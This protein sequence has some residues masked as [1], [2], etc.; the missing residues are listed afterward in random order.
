[1]MTRGIFPS[2]LMKERDEVAGLYPDPE[3]PA[4]AS[5]L[6]EKREFYDSRSIAAQ[7]TEGVI[8]PCSSSKA[9]AVFE[10]TPVQRL[11]SR[12][13]HPLTPYLGLLL[14]HGVGVGK[15]CS[16]V[17]IAEQFLDVSPNKVILLVPQAIQENFKKTIFDPAKL[18]WNGSSWSSQQCTRNT[19]LERLGLLTNPD[20]K[21]VTFAVEADRRKRYTITGYQAFANWIQ[22]SLTNHVPAGIEGDAKQI[23]ENEVLRK[24]FSDHLIIVDEAHNLRDVT[25]EEDTVVSAEAGENAGGKALNPFLKRIVLHAEGL[26]LVFMTATPMYNSAPEILRLLNFLIMNDT[27]REDSALQITDIFGPNGELQNSKT[28][29]D[30]ARRY[31]SYMRGEN[32]YT[33][34]LRMRPPFQES[35]SSQW[36]TVS[37][38]K[39]RVELTEQDRAA[40]DV[41][42]LIFTEPEP[43]SIVE[44]ALRGATSRGLEAPEQDQRDVMLDLRMQMSNITYPNNMYGTEGW[45]NYFK[46]VES[47]S[48]TRKIRTFAPKEDIRSVFRDN[49]KNHAPKI[50]RIVDS[51][52]SAQG[53]CFVYSRY[54]KSG[55]LP[56]AAALELAGFQRRLSDGSVVPLLSGV[57]PP[58]PICAICSSTH[59]NPLMGGGGGEAETEDHPFTPAYYILLTSDDEISPDFSGLV[60]LA[61]TWKDPLKGPLGTSV[62]VIIGSQVASEGLDLKCI[63]EMHILD[64]WY[65]L[66]RTDQIIGRAI[67][68]CSHS[69]LRPIERE[70]GIAPMAYNNC[71]IYMHVTIVKESERGPGFETADMYAY[72]L[73]IRKARNIGVVQ[74]VLKKHAWDCNLELEAIIFSGLPTR[75]QIDAQGRELAEY[76]LNDQDYTTYCD[77]Q[78]CKHECVSSISA[79]GGI[80]TS[81]YHIQDARREILSKMDIV[82][83]LFDDQV[84]IP[85]SMVQE[86][87]QDLPWEIRSEALLE[88]IDGKR[89]RIRRGKTE[90]YLIKKAGFL[91]FQPINIQDTDIPL[92]LRYERAFQI[93]RKF[94]TLTKPMNP[95]MEEIV[96]EKFPESVDDIDT[97]WTAWDTFLKGGALPSF[98]PATQRIWI[99]FRNHFVLPETRTIG[100]RWFFDKICSYSQKRTL[101]EKALAGNADLEALFKGDYIKSA[102]I[103]AYSIFNTETHTL[104]YFCRS[105]V[106]GKYDPCTSNTVKAIEISMKKTPIKIPEDVGSLVGFLAPKLDSLIFKTLDTTKPMKSKSGGAECGNTSNLPEHHPRIRL[107]HEAGRHDS[108]LASYIIPDADE[109]WNE[110]SSKKH[111]QAYTPKHMKDFTHQPLCLYMEFLCRLLDSHKVDGKR[112]FLRPEEALASGLKS[113]KK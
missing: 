47:R 18:K 82:R 60:R 17:S 72:R 73:A 107:L 81:T 78:I 23:A 110:S 44:E 64:S 88:L 112:W 48:A 80:N 52:T 51:I 56:L 66:N 1:M 55:A 87:F 54:I 50:K 36:P 49:L 27:K 29:E 65:H 68:Y 45:T 101:L 20:L 35:N 94:M 75:L 69:A 57:M 74:R 31:V 14:F 86:V 40:L 19:Y 59:S 42:P 77:Y 32:P 26:R 28:L 6:F 102:S 92:A 39:L 62:K 33:F 91:L 5:R 43:N 105:A 53:I 10:L 7:I 84:M 41:L 63:R 111:M 16:A 103:S 9:E 38:T 25:E 24:L 15:T 95:I 79:R 89:F 113:K 109:E 30:A 83:H 108:T 104:D 13:M 2:A 37:A 46:P 12:F 11:V 96:L 98:I 21:A 8:D 97:K 61:T 70:R 106:S 93:R 67:R 90:G 34:P 22:R 71:L 100:L 85:E 58:P 99:W 76:S 3:D 4:F